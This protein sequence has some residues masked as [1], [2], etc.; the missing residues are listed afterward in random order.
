MLYRAWDDRNALLH[1]KEKNR[2]IL[3]QSE[4]DT[5]IGKV[6]TRQKEIFVRDHHLFSISETDMAKSSPRKKRRV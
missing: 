4:Y 5:K 2:S 3:A 6:Y 1:N